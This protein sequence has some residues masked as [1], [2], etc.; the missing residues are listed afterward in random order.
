ML[1]ILNVC[2]TTKYFLEKFDITL[3][4]SLRL[5]IG[6]LSLLLSLL[7]MFCIRFFFLYV[8]NPNIVTAN[9]LLSPEPPVMPLGK[10]APLNKRKKLTKII[11]DLSHIAQDGKAG[12]KLHEY[13]IKFPYAQYSSFI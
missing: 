3:Y 2:L 5:K 10:P 12:M 1:F 4:L 11:T 6:S 7:N 8:C 9:I 13:E